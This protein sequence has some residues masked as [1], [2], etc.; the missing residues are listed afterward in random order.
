MSS[1]LQEITL[2]S[3]DGVLVATNDD[4]HLVYPMLHLNRQPVPSDAQGWDRV[5]I[6]VDKESTIN[7]SPP[8]IVLNE[9]NNYFQSLYIQAD[10][11]WTISDVVEDFIEL[12]SSTGQGTG[13]GNARI[14]ITKASSLTEQGGY[15]SQF[16]ITLA[17]ADSTTVTI[18]VYINVNVPLTVNGKGTGETVTINLDGANSYTETLTIIRDREWSLENVDNGTIAVSPPN[19]N[20]EFLPDFV[21]TLTV[22][23]SPALTTTTA[24]ATFQVVSLFQT[25]NVIVNITTT[26]TGEFVDPLP[27]EEGVT[28]TGDIYLY[29]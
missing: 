24:T 13:V 23:K 2:Q 19:G 22:T 8:V 18:P 9:E 3:T 11:K 6:F 14:D 16:S 1:N 15:T 28:G 10:G 5:L 25:V 29:V 26:I 17:D 27:S 4:G 20:G 21:S 12:D 7:V